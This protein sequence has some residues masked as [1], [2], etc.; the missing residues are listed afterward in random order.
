MTDATISRV[1]PTEP[2][3]LTAKQVRERLHISRSQWYRV[4]GKLPASYALG[5]QSP[6]YIWSEV[7]K[8]LA[9]T[10]AAA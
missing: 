5:P 10:G 4:A 7:V 6:R 3:V 8:F 9:D 2:E 1:E